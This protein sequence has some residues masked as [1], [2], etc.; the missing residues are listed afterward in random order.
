MAIA[1]LGGV[2]GLLAERMARLGVGHLKIAD[3]E[4]FE[5]SNLNRQFGSSTGTI[6]GKKARIMAD[7]LQDIN[8]HMKLE[9]YE[10]GINKTN[11]ARF[12]DGADISLMA[13]D[14]E[15]FSE[16]VLL[17]E[18]TRRH[19]K[20]LITSGI[21]GFCASLMVL[22]PEGITLAQFFTLA[23]PKIVRGI[24]FKQSSIGPACS[25]AVSLAATEAVVRLLNKRKS[26]DVPKYLVY[27]LFN[28]TIQVIDHSMEAEKVKEAMRKIFDP[29]HENE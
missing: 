1:G 10:E 17:D 27:D 11:V 8:P 21:H 15:C 24:P 7:I 25:L 22:P 20:T 14:R 12:V 29:F 18:E 28:Q 9:V 5:C 3:P 2:G 19:G 26:V 13:L 16:M 6:G 23:F 4:I